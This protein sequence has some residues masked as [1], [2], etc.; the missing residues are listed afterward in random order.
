VS[1]FGE[2]R[3]RNVVKVAVAYAIVGWVLI[4]VSTTVL[5]LFEAPDWIAQVFAF[6]IIAGFPVALILSWAYD[7][8]PGGIERTKSEPSTGSDTTATGRTVVFA[9][10]GALV[11]AL[12]IVVY[13]YVLVDSDPAAV[14]QDATPF[15]EP[16]SENAAAIE[17]VEQSGVLPNSVAV[18]PFENLSLDPEDA[19][20]AAGIHEETLNQLAKIDNLSVISRTSVLRYEDSDLSIPE[21]ARE[22][23][24]ETVM[25]GSV[26]YANDRVRIT[27]Q[28]ID[29]TTDEHLWSEVYERDLADVFAIQSD[30]A[31]NIAN[32]LEAEFSI[33]EQLEI[34]E[35]PT[36]SPEAYAQYLRAMT[37]WGGSES[38]IGSL[39]VRNNVASYLNQAIEAD[40]NFALAYVQR[41]YLN[42][43]ILNM[44]PV[45]G[46]DFAV[47]RA[48]LEGLA[49]ADL[50][51]A[52]ALDPDLGAAHGILARIHQ[53]NWR[54]AAARGA[55]ERALELSPNDPR[56]LMDYANFNAILSQYEDAFRL[57]EHAIELDP[58][59]G[60]NYDTLSGIHSHAGD[61]RAAAAAARRAIELD[62]TYSN[63]YWDLAQYEALL[64]NDDEALEQLLIAERLFRDNMNPVTHAG[65][66]YFYSMIDRTDD[67]NRLFRQLQED[68]ATRSIPQTA[69]IMAYLAIGDHEGA[70][71]WMNRAADS[72][73]YYEGHF[74]MA[75][76]SGNGYHD[77][78]LDQPEFVAV[79]QRLCFTDL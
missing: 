50:D 37:I 32:A 26:R 75:W 72:P 1:F 14:V 79:R 5:P 13:N 76:M 16:D 8:T 19:F 47:R 23:N 41:A 11:L 31:M 27:A 51:R 64:G 21:I 45:A 70:L 22:L 24:V 60:I 7:L 38:L 71:E 67:V 46:E 66:A 6:F 42:V 39:S 35:A 18:L 49:L 61:Q 36:D 10:I 34:E 58:N 69:W 73:Q 54:G 55:Y 65:T 68:S 20:F 43:V 53:Y 78:V 17:E 3:R 56:I 57:A 33:E 15:V 48:E 2:L 25:E 44:G 59:S 9:I 77:P 74:G 52:L 40:E 29:A 28:L 63:A 4:E 62:P 30:I 12:G